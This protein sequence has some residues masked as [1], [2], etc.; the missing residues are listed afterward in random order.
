MDLDFYNLI[1]AQQCNI[2]QIADFDINNESKFFGYPHLHYSAHTKKCL[3]SLFFSID[4]HNINKDVVDLYCT[5]QKQNAA[6][7]STRK[8]IFLGGSFI[9]LTL[10]CDKKVLSD[11]YCI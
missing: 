3:N 2:Q 8:T 7:I 6:G 9:A 10:I 4:I 5:L 11:S 1:L